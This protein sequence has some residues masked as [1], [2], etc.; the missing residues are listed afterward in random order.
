MS[1]NL[2]SMSAR[3]KEMLDDE[4]INEEQFKEF[5]E[6]L[7]LVSPGRSNKKRWSK[8]LNRKSVEIQKLFSDNVSKVKK[9]LSTLFKKKKIFNSY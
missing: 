3:G 8:T 5:K 7:N 9:D 4:E 6:K 1:I 2:K